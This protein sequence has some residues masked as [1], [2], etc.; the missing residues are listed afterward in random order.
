MLD[1]NLNRCQE[2]LRVSEDLLRFEFSLSMANEV[3]AF[4]HRFSV[5]AGSLRNNLPDILKARDSDGDIMRADAASSYDSAEQ[6]LYA[7]F[8][9]LKEALRAVEEA[10]RLKGMGNIAAEAADLRF[11][12]Y[13]LEKM[14]INGIGGEFIKQLLDSRLNLY[15][16]YDLDVIGVDD[17]GY[18]FDF[19]RD[20]LNAGADILQVRF[21]ERRS[22]RLV[23]ELSAALAREFKGKKLIVV[24]NRADIA[25]I[26]KAGLHIGQGDLRARDIRLGF[27]VGVVGLSCHSDREIEEAQRLPVDYF[28]IGPIFPT[29]TKPEYKVVGMDL[30]KKWYNKAEKPFV[31][32]GGIAIEYAKQIR[33]FNPW[34]IA[35]CRDILE[36]DSP[37]GKVAQYKEI[38]SKR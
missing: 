3:K 37:S 31:A 13:S 30:L 1:A 11:D 17:A 5:F 4:R 20:L 14:C 23:G 36:A 10:L 22:A 38:L 19:A 29:R 35:V 21:S 32:I 28:S 7:N 24:N 2:A 6:A 27:K 8:Q 16:I 9:R 18:L 12:S 26:A 33:N 34:A 15:V 25:T